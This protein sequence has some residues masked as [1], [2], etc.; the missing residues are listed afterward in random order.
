MPVPQ[1]LLYAAGAF[2]LGAVIARLIRYCRQPVHLRW[3][4]YPVAHE[5]G[6]AAYGGS[7]FEVFEHWRVDR[8]FDSASEV[9]AFMAEVLLLD[10][11]RRHNRPLWRFSLPFHLGAYLLIVW[12]GLLLLAGLFWPM[13]N[14]LSPVAAVITVCGFAGLGLNL[15][16]GL[17]LLDRR[18]RDPDL[19][20]YNAPADLFNLALWLVYCGWTLGVHAAEG[21]FY[22]LAIFAGHWLRL[23]P[24]APPSWPLAVSMILGAM[25]LAYLPLSRMFHFVAKYFL[26]HAVRWDDAPNPRGGALEGRLRQSLALDLGWKAPH[27]A[28]ARSWQ[29]ATTPTQKDGSA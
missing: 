28:A 8:Q 13:G 14:G 7:H 25:L 26:Y 21:G 6:R 23:Q 24:A 10:G 19:R 1:I 22:S 11:V 16:G 12:L 2:F 27:A 9:R 15:I 29:D 3:E 5:M 20:T 4:L 17:G 18:L